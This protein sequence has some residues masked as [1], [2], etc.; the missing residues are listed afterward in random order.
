MP[1]I[2]IIIPI[3]NAE[4][5]V[6]RCL[7][8]IKAQSFVDF[9]AIMVNDG[10]T[11]NSLQILDVY[12]REDDRFVIIDKPN[13]GVSSARQAGLD[14]AKGEFVIHA[15]PDDYVSSHWLEKLY[16]TIVSEQSDMVIC[17]YVRIM[18]SKQMVCHQVLENIDARQV[19]IGILKGKI[20]SVTWNKLVRR[21][22]IIRNNI[23][24]DFNVG[25]WEDV[26][27]N[28]TLLNKG[29]KVSY[30]PEALYFYDNTSNSNSFVTGFK[31]KDVESMLHVYHQLE[32]EL[33]ESYL[34]YFTYIK[35]RIKY[36]IF[37]TKPYD[38]DKYVNTFNEIND[39][40]I[41]NAKKRPLTLRKNAF[42][43]C[44]KGHHKIGRFLALLDKL[45]HK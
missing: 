17:D 22:H 2:S 5:Y 43:M 18:K 3:Y 30:V 40:I 13:G 26:L 29:I 39:E 19:I 45:F 38:G 21:E 8:S 16:D 24:F 37:Y 20:W 35:K 23:S 33:D 32:N 25:F 6:R 1:K 34:P 31:P 9:E 11:D 10:S 36:R 14:R 7:D 27:F 12:S 15:D 41:K 44:L 42:A 28:C 4:A